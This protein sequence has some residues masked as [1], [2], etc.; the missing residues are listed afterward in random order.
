MNFY[1]MERKATFQE[2]IKTKHR[3]EED[4]FVNML[5]LKNDKNIPIYQFYGFDERLNS[6]IFINTNLMNLILPHYLLWER[7]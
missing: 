6:Y 1:R 7:N 5:G 3:I 2:T 4:I